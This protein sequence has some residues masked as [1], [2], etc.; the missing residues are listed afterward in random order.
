MALTKEQKRALLY[1]SKTGPVATQ[2]TSAERK[3]RLLYGDSVNQAKP[4][5]ESP[6]A[7]MR[8][9]NKSSLGVITGAAP[10]TQAE[11]DA[12]A[13]ADQEGSWV[14]EVAGAL[15]GIV[16][17]APAAILGALGGAPAG[18]ALGTAIAPSVGTIGGAIGGAAVGFAVPATIRSAYEEYVKLQS[19]PEYAGMSME[20]VATKIAQEGLV[21]G[22][23]GFATGALVGLVPELG[24][25]KKI[26][27]LN[28]LLSTPAGQAV[29]RAASSTAGK[30]AGEA[31]VLTAAPAILDGQPPTLEGFALNAGLLGLIKGALKIPSIGKKVE[32][33]K[34]MGEE[35]DVKDLPPEM[36]TMERSK[37]EETLNKYLDQ[38][39]AKAE[40][41]KAAAEAKA[42]ESIES[43]S[44][45]A[46]AKLDKSSPESIPESDIRAAERGLKE[47]ESIKR[48]Q[49]QE[50]NDITR[51]Q[52]RKAKSA[53]S[54]YKIDE[55]YYAS[56][57]AEEI[58]AADKKLKAEEAQIK[59][60]SKIEL[61][62][63]EELQGLKSKSAIEQR[64]A[65]KLKRDQQIESAKSVADSVKSK[66]ELGYDKVTRAM[67]KDATS[68]VSKALKSNETLPAKKIYKQAQAA[69][70]T[71]N[72]ALS[73]LQKS[74]ASVMDRANK[75]FAKESKTLIDRAP[76]EA[77]LQRSISKI[78]SNN[79]KRYES[80]L[81]A[82]KRAIE[83][84]QRKY[85]K[86]VERIKS[87]L[88]EA[89]AVANNLAKTKLDALPDAQRA[90]LREQLDRFRKDNLDRRA[91]FEKEVK[92]WEQGRKKAIEDRLQKDIER[93][94]QRNKQKLEEAK[95][96][97][98][99]AKKSGYFEA[100]ID[101]KKTRVRVVERKPSDAGKSSAEVVASRI[102]DRPK[103]SKSKSSGFEKQV[104]DKYADLRTG[105]ESVLRD[106]ALMLERI[107]SAESVALHSIEQGVVD[108]NTQELISSGYSKILQ[109]NFGKKPV[110]LVLLDS[111]LAAQTSLQRQ[112]LGQKNP[113]PTADA[114]ALINDGSV[115][116]KTTR[117]LA[118]MQNAL[119]DRAQQA[120]VLSAQSVKNMKEAHTLYAPLQRVMDK[121][122]QAFIRSRSNL[123][124]QLIKSA[125]GS[126]RDI[127]SPSQVMIE[128]NVALEYNIAKNEAMTALSAEMKRNGYKAEA[129]ESKD[130]TESAMK[131]LVGDDF[132][133]TPEVM[134]ELNIWRDISKVGAKDD[135]FIYWF[136]NG[137]QMRMFVP[138]E[139]HDIAR[140]ATKPELGMAERAVEG[141]RKF[142]S[143][144]ITSFP[145][146][147][148]KLSLLD[149]L[150]GGLQTKHG[151]ANY[152]AALPRALID[153]IT[154][155]GT[156]VDFLKSGGGRQAM[157]DMISNGDMQY[158]RDSLSNALK[159][160][161]PGAQA[162]MDSMYGI[163]TAPFKALNKISNVLDTVPRLAEYNNSIKAAK[164][165]AK[166]E[167]IPY[168]PKEA[169]YR[170]AAD[171]YEVTTPYGREG[172][173][174]SI[175]WMNRIIPFARTIMTSTHTFAK[176]VNPSTAQGRR[177]LYRA[178]LALTIPTIG[179]YL[180]NRNDP[181]YL[182]KTEQDRSNNI[183]FFLSDDPDDPG[184]KIR[185]LWQYGWLFQTLPEKVI[186]FMAQDNPR[187]L[188]QL[189]RA[190]EFEFSPATILNFSDSVGDGGAFVA[191]E[192]LLQGRF[193]T[194][195]K[196]LE[197]LD[198][199]FQATELTSELAKILGSKIGVL[200]PVWIDHVFNLFGAKFGKEAL[201]LIDETLIGA[202][203]APD[204]K[205]GREAA[206]NILMGSFFGRIGKSSAYLEDFY[207]MANEQN[208]R[209]KTYS[210]LIKKGREDE[211]EDYIKRKPFVD[212][213][214]LTAK[215]KAITDI[216]KRIREVE[217]RI[218]ENRSDRELKTKERLELIKEMTD[219]AKEYASE[220][221]QEIKDLG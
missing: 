126:E 121:D 137:K 104:F 139:I 46:E 69:F 116:A 160:K 34:E 194:V 114:L 13:A 138:K 15:G 161:A 67:A 153:S 93:V 167:G 183:Y 134:K 6:N 74:M 70:D 62:A 190:F 181:R 211:A 136:E 142:N 129:F 32:K 76:L 184:I 159:R 80:K 140:N 97:I 10:K 11:Y 27:A 84:A 60:L 217:G 106:P 144:A 94:E 12:Y 5:A 191:P 120:S 214:A 64:E 149:T 205:M 154:R 219:L 209:Y 85:D 26:P 68:S 18:A 20:Q 163:V 156:F 50:I 43:V 78:E 101:G 173:S 196:R 164:A 111:H 176:N 187:A 150:Q 178:T 107:N 41:A 112:N 22:A 155:S 14:G 86:S 197:D 168:N 98:V 213:S 103:P 158:A 110:D 108:F 215:K 182:R 200:S 88:Q 125:K 113:I 66:V 55:E 38:E 145:D 207:R 53:L 100:D 56:R 73:T 146:T 82:H 204:S 188:K 180:M 212:N 118:K 172:A 95:Q 147:I 19:L 152:I 25:L 175:Q 131:E 109:E 174:M 171:A 151:V 79:T 141:F 96:K 148:V 133:L 31:A 35:I 7:F 59:Q 128:N 4:A 92:D 170:A 208:S 2:E 42:S 3:R 99:E 87:K 81:K 83:D 91:A 203:I 52:A 1:G 162:F 16:G 89:E 195:P 105:N 21:G 115:Y 216:G 202:G 189:M 179:A 37:F 40:S 28:K 210:D 166:A 165:K 122:T 206:D 124:K 17:D 39:I 218:N 75:E 123:P 220:L 24:I 199:E 193:Q 8:G 44:K 119:L 51:T 47:R 77:D 71:F 192:K 45:K 177:G 29:E 61:K 65:I 143:Q 102:K 23:K 90:E 9:Y 57:K 185:K 221:R 127:I 135:G 186:D 72:G 130:L 49:A 58:K 169:N 36:S 63:S 201:N 30:I 54:D 117:D 132:V 157:H 33:L 198:P 48:E